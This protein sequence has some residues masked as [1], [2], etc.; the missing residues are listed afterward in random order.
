MNKLFISTYFFLA[1]SAR[2]EEAPQEKFTDKVEIVAIAV[3]DVVTDTTETV[4]RSLH[5]GA[6]AAKGFLASTAAQIKI[7]MHEAR[8]KHAQQKAEDAHKQKVQ[9][10]QELAQ[11]QEQLRQAQAALKRTQQE[12]YYRK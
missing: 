4:R 12:M 8:A 7:K 11:V 3:K 2:A 5:E 9:V 1:L 6:E 10:Q